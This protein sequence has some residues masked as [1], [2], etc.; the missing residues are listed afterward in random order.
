VD[1]YKAGIGTASWTRPKTTHYGYISEVVWTKWIA[2]LLL[3]KISLDQFMDGCTREANALL[4]Q[5]ET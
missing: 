3:G 4:A 2:Q 1:W 5:G